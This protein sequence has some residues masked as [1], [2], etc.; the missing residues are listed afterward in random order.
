MSSTVMMERT[1]MGVQG[2]SVPG[3]GTPTMGAPTGTPVGTNW[4]MVPRCTFKVEKC[5]G[6]FK[7][8]CHCDDK[9]ACSMVQNLCSMLAGG[10]CSCCCMYNG[11]TVAYWNFTQGVCKCEATESGVQFTCTTGDPQ[12]AKM[13]QSWCECLSCMLECGCNCCFMI[14]NTP[15][16]CGCSETGKS[17]KSK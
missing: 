6:G 12:C 17:G 7:V 13:V 8:S 9:M 2:M 4:L 14:N 3:L 10:L 11:M 16:C 5:Q 1:G 15:V